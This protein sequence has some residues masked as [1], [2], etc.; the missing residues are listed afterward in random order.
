MTAERWQR[1]KELLHQAMQL[2]PEQRA[3]YLDQACATDHDLRA[4]V[5]S[6]LQANEEVR[7]TFMQRTET[8]HAS[9]ADR[10]AGA[11]NDRLPTLSGLP[12]SFGPY[13]ILEPV[14]KGGMGEVFRGRDTRLRRSVAI[15]VLPADLRHDSSRLARFEREARAA[16]ALNH[17]NI[18]SVYDIGIQDDIPFI[19]SEWIEGESL[20]R[21]IDKGPAPAGKLMQIANQLA[22]GLRAAHA[23]GIVHRDLKPENIMLTPD[24]RVKILDFG[25][26]KHV[27]RDGGPVKGPETKVLTRPGLML[28]TIRYLSPEQVQGKTVDER[29]DIFSLGAV[30]YELASGKAAFH[31]DKLI[32]VLNAIL[33]DEPPP[34]K[35]DIPPSVNRII[36]RCLAKDPLQRFQNA[37]ELAAALQAVG[38]ISKVR[39]VLWAFERRPFRWWAVTTVVAAGCAGLITHWVQTHAHAGPVAQSRSAASRPVSQ[40]VEVVAPPEP[41][42][43]TTPEPPESGV[44]AEPAPASQA[45]AVSPREPPATPTQAAV[46][47]TVAGQRWKFTGDG[48]PAR[49]VALGHCDDVRCDG[50]GNIYATDWGNEAVV[51]IDRNGILHVLAGP[52]SPPDDRPHSPHFLAVDHAGAIY[53]SQI[54]VI[55]KF[56]P[57]GHVTLV[58]GRH[59]PGFSPDGAR[60][61][62][63]AIADVTGMTLA[64]DGSVIFSELGNRQVRR[65]DPQGNLQTIAGSGAPG[66]AGDGGPAQ[67]ASLGGPRGVALD[68]AGNLFIADPLN[69]CVR[70][71]ARDQRIF[72]V[73]GHGIAGNLGCPSGL[74]V[75]RRDDLFIAD[76]CKGQIFV[77]RDSR[78]SVF[79]GS[80]ELHQEPSAD[81][82]AA[83]SASFDEWALAFDEHDNLLVAG[84]DF[85]HIYQIS[86]DG[87]FHIIAGSG[88]WGVT[89]QETPA[90][91]AL[92]QS[93][94]RLAVDGAGN[95]FITDDGANRIYRLD[96]RGVVTHIAGHSGLS[97]P[98]FEGEDTLALY[99][100]LNSPQGIRARRDG[101]LV[102]ADRDNNR[103]REITAAGRLRTLAGNGARRFSGDGGRALDAALNRPAGV[104]L[105]SSGDV[106]VADTGN[107]RIRKFT[108]G[109]TIVTVAGNG[110]AGYSGDGGPADKAAL[111]TPSAVEM[112]ANGDLFI[113]DTENHC[114]RRVS[115]G[116]ITTLAGDGQPGYSGDGSAASSA[117]LNSPADL[118]LGVH[119]Q[120]FVLDRANHRIRKID[121]ASCVITT[122]AGSGGSIASGDGGPA[123]QASLG[124][125]GGIAADGAGNVYVTDIESRQVR[126]IHGSL[127]TPGR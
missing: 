85:G 40:P 63:S 11:P 127:K 124:R 81:G 92:F 79:A 36:R 64:A 70:K 56:L 46:I 35:A 118:A 60:A 47:E 43:K 53:F 108:A 37:G 61:Q 74:A 107:H 33:G 116:V 117:R 7:S 72:T 28:G 42:R 93:P 15:K 87:I 103:V 10:A 18:V 27:T 1:V 78:I 54:F 115:N 5:D 6:L 99:Y 20:R 16:G 114:I 14:A 112:D 23:A 52:D 9:S 97:H 55:R 119:R 86:R 45:E 94:S 91:Q 120:L 26:A 8:T 29:S 75:N 80:G 105:D 34:L 113:A 101:T 13:E 12:A 104:C 110:M 88:L 4:E 77:L 125:P 62:G 122:F 25:L 19:V 111:N 109:G 32:D 44:K 2:T 68:S 82:V 65:V 24:M 100:R 50:E 84:P 22:A 51:K 76:P 39:R 69:H 3:H 21:L 98:S 123:T 102:F 73:A 41:A 38:D 66:F 95:V 83:I 96:R 71:V 30:L 49:Q 106:Y 58:A 67:R 31:R 48:M 90:S 126:L 17:P 57:G 121:L 59:A 89:R